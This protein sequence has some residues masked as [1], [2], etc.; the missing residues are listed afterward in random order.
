MKLRLL[1]GGAAQALVAAVAPAFQ[2]QTGFGIDGAFGAVGA[3]KERLLVGEPADLLIL[4]R[5]LIDALA[6]DGH[7][8]PA[9]VADIGVVRTA[10]AVR[11][12]DPAPHVGDAAGLRQALRAA[13][14]IY[15]PDMTLSTAGVHFAKVLQG[16]G[17]AEEVAGRLRE[18]P[19]GSAAMGALAASTDGQP[20]G[21]TQVTEILGTSGLTLV[22]VLP[23]GFELATVYT[24]GVAARAQRRDAA[25]RLAAMLTSDGARP[26]REQVGFGR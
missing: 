15:A 6:A 12:A 26:L 8:D 4:T 5:A 16:L 13:E 24:L 17:I 23:A 18:F 3:M 1:S 19:N 14:A 9:S 22:D 21:C 10:V 20:I 7:V 2:R 25:R 11:E